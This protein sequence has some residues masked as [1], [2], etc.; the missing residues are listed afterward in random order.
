[1][2]PARQ[3]VGVKVDGDALRSD[4]AVLLAC[5]HRAVLRTQPDAE[6]RVLV[7]IHQ[8]LYAACDPPST[9]VK[10]P[11][12][13]TERRPH[14]KFMTHWFPYLTIIFKHARER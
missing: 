7:L 3:V 4:D 13:T 9:A 6:Y 11:Q 5:R 1:M 14:L 2:S 10:V 8:P 12:D